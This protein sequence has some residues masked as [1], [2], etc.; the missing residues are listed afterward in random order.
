MTTTGIGVSHTH[1]VSIDPHAI[2][3]T[4]ANRDHPAP[5]VYAQAA[6]LLNAD[7]G[8]TLYAHNPFL[9]LP[10][11]ST[12]KLMTALLAV[13]HGKLDQ[14]VT[15]N[16]EIANEIH[17]LPVD[18]SNIGLKAGKSYTLR[19]MLYGLLL[20]SGNDAGIAIADTIGGSYTHFISMMNQKAAAMGLYDTHFENPHGLQNTISIW[21]CPRFGHSRSV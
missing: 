19:Q 8:A 12:T 17:Q 18:S 14:R 3:I 20:A 6:Y 15:I 9:H 21:E 2:M 7:T 1:K 13:E 5:P 16:R 4:P 10:I 11:M